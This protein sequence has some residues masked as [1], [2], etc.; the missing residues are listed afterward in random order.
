MTIDLMTFLIMALSVYRLT[1]LFVKESG[2]FDIF[3]RFRTFAGIKYDIYSKPYATNQFAEGLL[4]P[5]C[6]SIWIGILITLFIGG[7]YYLGIENVVL[8]ILMPFALSG[9]SV[10]LF[11]Q[12][13]K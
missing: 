7:G 4:C 8:F 12:M 5:L 9:L 6:T 10:Y 2:P 11:E 1:S 3:G 13:D